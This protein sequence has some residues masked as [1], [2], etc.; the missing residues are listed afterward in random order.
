MSQL[1]F[2]CDMDEMVLGAKTPVTDTEE[3]TTTKVNINDLSDI[4]IMYIL[5]LLS[6]ISPIKCI[7]SDQ[8][9]VLKK[10][11]NS[12]SYMCFIV[13]NNLNQIVGFAKIFKE[14][15]LSHGLKYVYHIEDVVVE[16]NLHNQ[17]IGSKLINAIIN[18]YDY[19]ENVYKI[20]LVCKQK[21]EGFYERFKFIK[22]DNIEMYM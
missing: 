11:W 17:G 19:D 18:E 3:Y 2:N 7:T 16:P 1:P 13:K 10:V 15:K 6:Q 4:D 22:T 9:A 21:N 8:I 20:K 5:H 12:E 14:L